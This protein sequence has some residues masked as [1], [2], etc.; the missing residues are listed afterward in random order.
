MY[1]FKLSNWKDL[2]KTCLS[3][4]T[5]CRKSFVCATLQPA[6]ELY[7]EALKWKLQGKLYL[8]VTRFD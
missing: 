1:P 7:M 4:K 3:S 6:F 8:N 2:I 5:E